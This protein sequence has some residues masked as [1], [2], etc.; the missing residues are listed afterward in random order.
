MIYIII[1]I[2]VSSV[3]LVSSIKNVRRLTKI[4]DRFVSARIKIKEAMNDFYE[5]R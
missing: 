5:R 3:A 1:L 4:E 2:L